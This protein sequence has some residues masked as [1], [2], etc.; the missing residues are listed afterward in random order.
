MY[1]HV[2]RLLRIVL[3]A[4]FALA[5]VGA[6]EATDSSASTRSTGATLRK[7]GG[8]LILACFLF[9]AFVHFLLW[10]FKDRLF[11]RHRHLLLGVSSALP[12]L[13]VRCVYS[14]LSAFS[15]ISSFGSNVTTSLP[16]AKHTSLSKFS[17]FSGSWQ[18]FLAMSL[19]MEYIVVLIYLA[20]GAVTPLQSKTDEDEDIGMKGGRP[21]GRYD[22]QGGY[23]Q[24]GRYEQ[25]TG[26]NS[27]G[28]GPGYSA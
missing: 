1:P 23:V 28:N 10:T 19:V 14:V 8:I 22:Q 9:M 27:Y 7:V 18:I 5:I 13:L 11:T 15:P 6:T 17:S 24:P 25:R 2:F 20:I 4:A 16:P 3:T 26:A 12:F 21:G